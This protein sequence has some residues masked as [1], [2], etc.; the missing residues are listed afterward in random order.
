MA[1]AGRRDEAKA[2]LDR[3]L[4]LSKQQYVSAY[5]IAMIYAAFRDADNMFLWMN[6]AVEE[7][8]PGLVMLARDPSLDFVRTDSRFAPLI[9]RIGLYRARREI[10]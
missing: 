10:P 5:D 8:A 2:G 1:L 4:A 6:R 3:A 7:R 9:A